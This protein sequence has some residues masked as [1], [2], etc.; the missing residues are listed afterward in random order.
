METGG[1]ERNGKGSSKFVFM[2]LLLLKLCAYRH[3][4][5]VLLAL[6]SCFSEA[7]GNLGKIRGPKLFS[8]SKP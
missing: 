3:L 5:T 2:I 8:A 1:G 4:W 7:Q 6:C